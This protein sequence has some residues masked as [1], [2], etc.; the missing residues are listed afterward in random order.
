M[1]NDGKLKVTEVKYFCVLL[2]FA[3]HETTANLI[4][5][6]MHLL[7]SQPELSETLQQ[8]PAD[9]PNFVDEIVRLF[10]P[11][12]RVVRRTEREVEIAGVK[13]PANSLV[14]LL[15][16]SANRDEAVWS[17][18]DACQMHRETKGNLG[19]GAGIHY[20]L[21]ASLARLEAR[22]ALEVLWRRFPNIRLDSDRKSER[23]LGFASGSLGWEKLYLRLEEDI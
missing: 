10:P 4:G 1:A 14:M 7:A 16:G 23:I 17:E 22:I 20:C 11:L 12:Q 5:N 19:F 15:L 2:L 13:I 8:T 3:G 9:L 18:P 6:A 21:G